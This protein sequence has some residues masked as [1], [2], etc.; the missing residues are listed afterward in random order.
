MPLINFLKRFKEIQSD[1]LF[2]TYS[3][4]K[5]FLEVSNS[6]LRKLIFLQK[7][8][9]EWNF[10]KKY[11]RPP[12]L[13]SFYIGLLRN[14]IK[15]IPARYKFYSPQESTG[16]SL[17]YPQRSTCTASRRYSVK[18]DHTKMGKICLIWKQNKVLLI[19]LITGWTVYT[20]K[21]KAQGPDV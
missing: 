7:S 4:M 19:S 12:E 1:L 6:V 20:E 5:L 8:I 3:A 13:L 10:R 17:I 18:F 16:V 2:S 15:N 9:R 11:F 14:F 21:Y